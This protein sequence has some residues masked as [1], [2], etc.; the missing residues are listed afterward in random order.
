MWPVLET[1]LER[2]GLASAVMLAVIIAAGIA[3]RELWKKQQDLGVQL[4]E[5]LEAES[6]KREAIRDAHEKQVE[7]LRAELERRT[8]G[9]IEH[10]NSLQEK[11]VEFGSTT[12]RE[13]MNLAAEVRDATRQ[14]A[15]AV[16]FLQSIIV[17][18]RGR[19]T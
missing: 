9:Y 7:A 5:T 12:T 1:T 16:M 10:L 18:D 15:D 2:Y 13:V 17:Q 4:R 6:K 14:Q 3:L 11:R 8:T 19:G